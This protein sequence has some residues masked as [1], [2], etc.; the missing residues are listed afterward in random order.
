MSLVHDLDGL[1]LEVLSQL[2]KGIWT[3]LKMLHLSECDLE[4]KGFLMLSQ[5]NWPCL[6]FLDITRNRLDAQGIAMLAKGNWP[7]LTSIILSLDP[8]VD[9]I[10]IAH[11]SA[12]N[13]PIEVL[14]IEDTSFNTEMAAELA[15][16][17]LPN[18]RVLHLMG[19]G[20][21]AAAVSELARADWPSLRDISIGHGHLD[22]VAVLLGFDLT[23]MQELKSDG[24]VHPDSEVY[25]RKIVSGPGVNLWPN[26]EWCSFSKYYIQLKYQ[27]SVWNLTSVI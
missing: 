1:G 11:L 19:P 9:A 17:Q 14:E 2:V 23:K 25:E 12:A 5:G 27:Q 20:L 15:D 22:A 16:L 7:S 13:W 24:C 4:V 21:T 3:Q 6:K 8:P 18:L 10:A 26:L